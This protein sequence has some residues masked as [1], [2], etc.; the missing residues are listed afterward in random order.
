M[1]KTQRI[2]LM[3]DW[4]PAACRAQGWNSSDRDLRLRTLG[5]AVGRE[6][7]SAS[8][9]NSTGDIDRVKAHLGG[10]A[11]K[12]APVI[13]HET[14]DED[15]AVRWRWLVRQEIRKLAGCLTPAPGQTPMSAA[16]AYTAALI[17]DKF[18]SGGPHVDALQPLTIDDLPLD[19][20]RQLKITLSQRQ[21]KL[22]STMKAKQPEPQA[23][24]SPDVE[25][26]IPTRNGVL[27]PF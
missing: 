11:N 17:R 8:D 12:L 3:A 20:L 18:Q 6:L 27:C 26:E 9:L 15:D 23:E 4:W 19:Q 2:T 16:M 1:T 13:K 10:L 14:P 5:E 25:T 24:P 22:A 21:A 7:E